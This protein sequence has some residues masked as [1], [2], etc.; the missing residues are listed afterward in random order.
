MDQYHFERPHL[1]AAYS[2]DKFVGIFVTYPEETLS[3]GELVDYFAI[4]SP[5]CF[6]AEE[7]PLEI[8]DEITP[9]NF[10]VVLEYM[11]ES[12]MDSR[13][14]DLSSDLLFM[15]RTLH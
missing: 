1:I 8:D 11:I 5:T 10:M 15:P 3:T 2:N 13:L 9:D 6:V 12:F 7:I 4:A 14:S